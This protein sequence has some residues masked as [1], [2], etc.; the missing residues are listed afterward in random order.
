MKSKLLLLMF[1]ARIVPAAISE[2]VM[3]PSRILVPFTIPV[4]TIGLVTVRVEI[5]AESKTVF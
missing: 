5:A 3:V 2:L 1:E 4:P